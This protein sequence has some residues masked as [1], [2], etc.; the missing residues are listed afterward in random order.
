MFTMNIKAF[1]K[2]W[3]IIPG[4]D[5]RVQYHTRTVIDTLSVTDPDGRQGSVAVQ[6]E[7]FLNYFPSGQTLHFVNGLL[8]TLEENSIKPYRMLYKDTVGGVE[9]QISDNFNRTALDK[10]FAV[11]TTIIFTFNEETYDWSASIPDGDEGTTTITGSGFDYDEDNPV[12]LIGEEESTGV[13]AFIPSKP[14]T[15]EEYTVELLPESY[16]EFEGAWTAASY[17][18]GSARLTEPGV[19]ITWLD[20]SNLLFSFRTGSTP[21]TYSIP[22]SSFSDGQWVELKDPA[23]ENPVLAEKVPAGVKVRFGGGATGMTIPP[24]TFSF[25]SAF[26]DVADTIQNLLDDLL[27]QRGP[28]ILDI[29]GSLD[30]YED[31]R[32]Y[33]KAPRWV[34]SDSG[35][36]LLYTLQEDPVT[37][38]YS[39]ELF[40][41]NIVTSSSPRVRTSTAKDMSYS[42]SSADTEAKAV[43][44]LLE[45]F[46]EQY[47]EYLN[48][49]F[50]TDTDEYPNSEEEFDI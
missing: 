9:I 37:E 21:L 19:S 45:L 41:G 33:Y 7:M 23:D 29:E 11:P 34:F 6:K 15:E 17:D 31:L 8:D 22:W 38:E 35:V 13:M 10:V 50:A 16:I 26:L 20:S 5:T 48:L 47:T 40:T 12:L 1:Q 27:F 46:K 3:P 49:S 32:P 25:E 14:A 18:D 39:W 28:D 36:P 2:R 30:R 44:S 4:S 42:L 24:A 43:V